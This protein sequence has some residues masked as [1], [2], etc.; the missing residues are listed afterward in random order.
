M[1][2][3]TPVNEEGIPLEALET[4]KERGITK[5]DVERIW[6]EQHAPL[7][8]VLKE[9]EVS[10]LNLKK[11]DVLVV[12]MHGEDF[13]H[14]LI[15]S[16]QNH[17]KKVFPSNKVLVFSLSEGMSMDLEV[18]KSRLLEEKA[19]CSSGPCEGCDCGKKNSEPEKPKISTP[20]GPYRIS[21]AQ[22]VRVIDQESAVHNEE[23]IVKQHIAG[24]NYLV[25]FMSVG[26]IKVQ[27]IALEEIK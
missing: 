23:G 15:Q 13:D 25:N 12:K 19:A 22:K 26:V 3:E 6:A 2:D 24:D 16:L 20:T 27:G 9:V 18:V 8:V 10:K 5:E 11:N 7:E 4:P 1:A 17:F 21:A 14:Q